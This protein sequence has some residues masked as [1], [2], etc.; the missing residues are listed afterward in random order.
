MIIDIIHSGDVMSIECERQPP[1]PGNPDGPRAP[2]IP[3]QLVQSRT[4]QIHVGRLRADIEG[5]QQPPQF[6]GVLSVYP[7]RSAGS[8]ETL[9]ALVLE[10]D[11][12][13]NP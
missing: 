10:P 9:E 11:N 4:R 6:I 2:T 7:T 12:H 3:F 13:C 8:I 1:I 5:G